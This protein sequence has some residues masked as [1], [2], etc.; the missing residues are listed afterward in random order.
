MQTSS[1]YAYH[2]TGRR[3]RSVSLASKIYRNVT[4]DQNATKHY[5]HSSAMFL[6][7]FAIQRRGEGAV[8]VPLFSS[9]GLM[10]VAIEARNQCEDFS[11]IIGHL[12]IKASK[13]NYERDLAV[14]KAWE[15]KKQ[16]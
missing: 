2:N 14:G 15:R 6:K 3:D 13:R 4:P 5:R 7:K 9:I 1:R 8:S 10:K 11:K 16:T 12:A